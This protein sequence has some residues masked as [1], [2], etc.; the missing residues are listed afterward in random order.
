MELEDY[1]YNDHF[2]TASEQID[3]PGLRPGRVVLASG[4]IHR[5]VAE[6]GELRASVSGRLRHEAASVTD[7]PAVGDWVPFRDSR[8]EAVLSR[9]TQL[10]RKVAGRRTAE[11]VVATNVDTVIVVMGLD[12]DFNPRRLER[13]LTTVWKSGAVPVVLLNKADLVEAIDAR[14]AEIEEIAIVAAVFVSSCVRGLDGLGLDEV[15]SL[16]R[17]RETAVLVGSSGV[18]KSTLI[19]RL[20]DENV[21]GGR[22]SQGPRPLK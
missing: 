12:G 6:D 19:N 16:L 10:S 17:P 3:M 8:I 4:E 11:Q 5:L 9:R 7:L 2:L 20:L 18:G 21:K 15:R 13:Y 1:G 14:R 22:I